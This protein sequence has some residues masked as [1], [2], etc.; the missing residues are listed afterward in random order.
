MNPEFVAAALGSGL[1][2]G[3]PIALAAM[4]GLFTELAGSLSVALEGAMLVGSYAAI[5]GW[6]ATGSPALALAL[7]AACGGT[8]GLVVGWVSARLKADVFVAGLAV[9]LLGPA[10]VALLSEGSFGSKGILPLPPALAKQALSADWTVLALLAA[11]IGLL[12]FALA[13]TPLGPRLRAAGEKGEA[14]RAAGLDRDALRLSAHVLAGAAAG[15]AGASL[16]LSIAAFVPGMSAG[17]GWMA[18][19][20]IYLG[21]R[22]PSTVLASSLVFGL[23]LALANLIQS[24]RWLPPELLPALPYLVTGIVYV[25]APRKPRPSG[26]H[27]VE[28][29]WI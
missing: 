20:A 13:A 21:G 15:L 18:L 2:S 29:K 4:G 23:L 19:V 9:N 11:V 1:A 24:N 6:I 26:K 14:A 5:H 27:P 16:S 3:L 25:F 8:A 12:W 17:R 10:L 7:A 28:A 22:R